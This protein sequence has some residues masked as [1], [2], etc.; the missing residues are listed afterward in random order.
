MGGE[1]GRELVKSALGRDVRQLGRH[2]PVVLA[3]GEQH[4][5]AAAPTVVLS[6][7]GLGQ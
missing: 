6:G 3:G 5:P 2:R 1:A 4:Y 7:K